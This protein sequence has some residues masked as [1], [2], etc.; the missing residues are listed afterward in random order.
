M[1]C[2]R[3][4]AQT[5]G[6]ERY[7]GVLFRLWLVQESRMWSL[8]AEVQGNEGHTLVIKAKNMHGVE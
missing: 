2:R 5:K 3:R 4:T 1:R 6:W 8:A 7:F